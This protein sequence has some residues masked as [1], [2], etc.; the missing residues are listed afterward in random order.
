MASMVVLFVPRCVAGGVNQCAEERQ[1]YSS[2]QFAERLAAL[3]AKYAGLEFV[4]EGHGIV[5]AWDRTRAAVPRRLQ[6]IVACGAFLAVSTVA[7]QR[8]PAVV[9]HCRAQD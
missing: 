1:V 5:G 4:A 2:H 3:Q 6:G 9:A 8:T 7:C